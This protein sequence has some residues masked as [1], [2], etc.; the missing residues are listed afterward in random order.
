M[1]TE[2]E[3]W[4]GILFIW[5]VLCYLLA[6]KEYPNKW[7][8][9][10]FSFNIAFVAAAFILALYFYPL[11]SPTSQYLYLAVLAIGL[12]ASILMFFWPESEEAKAT[13]NEK[14]DDDEEIGAFWETLGQIIFFFP[15]VAS[16]AL[17]LY[18]SID[19]INSLDLM[20]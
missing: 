20:G 8:V 1:L 18:K 6:H 4:G 15:V 3:W 19:I 14:S 13:L 9:D 11:E 12:L 10:Y 17:G 2:I 7:S 16:L 5:F